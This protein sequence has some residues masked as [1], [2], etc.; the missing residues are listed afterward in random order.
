MRRGLLSLL[1]LLAASAAAC[2]DPPSKEM[3]QAQGAIDAARAAGAERYAT[4]EFSAAVDALTRSEDAVK[5]RD[6]RLALNYALDSRE[7]AQNAAKVAADQK[8]VVRSEAERLLNETA[9]ALVQCS[10]RLKPHES[11]KAVRREVASVRANIDAAENAV[12]KA[13]AS[14]D[15][16]D[17][18]TARQTLRGAMDQT[19]QAARE[20]D[21]MP[22][23]TPQK[24]RG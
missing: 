15:G 4:A 24:K 13:R 19:R 6:Y 11:S 16:G 14:L 8:A 10:T 2:A 9:L 7:R 18:L 23:P 5:Q 20:L 17:Y 22:P 1:L 3:G 21:A 12:Q